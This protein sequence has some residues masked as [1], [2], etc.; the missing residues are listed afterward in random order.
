MPVL[1][2]LK[3]N[4]PQSEIFWWL[5]A[6]L[7]PLLEGD[8]DLAGIIPFQRDRW[9]A[10]RYWS[11][12]WKS[13]RHIRACAFDW[14]I[15]LQSLG[16]SGIVA[17]LANGQLTLGLDDP[18]EGARGFYDI[19]VRRPSYH[20]HAVDW[21]LEVLR[22]LGLPVHWDFDWF[23]PRPAV[24]AAIQEKWRPGSS[25][26]LILQ[27]GARWENKRWPVEY[28][29]ELVQLLGKARPEARFAILG[30]RADAGL[31]QAIARVHPQQCLDLTGQLTLPE[32]VEWIRLGEMMITNDTGPMHVAAALRKPIVALFGPTEPRRTGPYGQVEKSIQV[33]LPC[34]PCLKDYCAY[35]K[36]LECL[37]SISPLVVFA[38]VQQ[39]MT[40]VNA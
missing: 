23:P 12:A 19:I 11:E 5:D 36:P 14:V 6:S 18:R 4:L 25:R 2:L 22:P 8:P 30:S 31:G 13:M 21:Y 24:A 20:T 15:D 1:R 9:R 35:Q 3:Q 26:W 33:D 34:V 32:M 7:A 37:R 27:P 39:Q 16:R 10:P 28:F 38:R 40:S 17:W 29:V